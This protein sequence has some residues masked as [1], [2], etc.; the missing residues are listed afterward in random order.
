MSFCDCKIQS[1]GNKGISI[2]NPY[3]VILVCRFPEQNKKY[4][5]IA[6]ELRWSDDGQLALSERAN[7]FLAAM[8]SSANEYSLVFEDSESN[9]HIFRFEE[10]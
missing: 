9:V 10:N 6:P 3:H 1:F 8:Q 7:S 4:V 5:L 2:Q